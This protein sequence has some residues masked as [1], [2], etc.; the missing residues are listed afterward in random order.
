MPAVSGFFVALRPR[1]AQEL[2]AV[3]YYL[4]TPIYYANDVPTIGHAYTT[5]AADAIARY[6]RLQSEDVYLVTGTDEHGVNIERIAAQRETT[7][8][9]HVDRI[10]AAFQSLFKRLDITYDSFVRTSSKAHARAALELW[11]RLQ[12]SGDLYRGTYEGDYCP[13]CE[14]YYQPDE[15]VDGACPVHHLPCEH[16]A[17]ENW[18]FRLSRYAPQLEELVNDSDFV[19]PAWRR[20]ARELSVGCRLPG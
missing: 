1:F 8:R 6:R 7:P 20:R 2:R 15:L 17:E 4:T 5:I 19:Q 18:F 3:T 12:A 14:A 9:Q 13:R 16:V 10:A 11:R